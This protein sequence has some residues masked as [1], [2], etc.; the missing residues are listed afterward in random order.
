MDEDTLFFTGSGNFKCCNVTTVLKLQMACNVKFISFTGAMP[1]QQII[2]SLAPQNTAG[3]PIG[4]WAF[5]GADLELPKN[6]NTPDG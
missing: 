6:M 5:G 4:S 1:L 2:R 3:V